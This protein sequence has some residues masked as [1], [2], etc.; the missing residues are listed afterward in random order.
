MQY[1]RSKGAI[2]MNTIITNNVPRELP[3]AMLT[4]SPT[5]PR[6]VFD[7]AFLKELADFVPGHKIGILFRRPFCGR[8]SRMALG[9]GRSAFR[10][11]HKGSAERKRIQC[12]GILPWAGRETEQHHPRLRRAGIL[13]N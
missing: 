4:E 12:R 6:R 8:T 10:A 7:E 1:N 13:L 11:T 2:T 9:S 3:I 5:N